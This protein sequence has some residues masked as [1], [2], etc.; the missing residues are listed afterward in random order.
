MG[1]QNQSV[2]LA[3]LREEGT[4][5]AGEIARVIDLNTDVVEAHLETLRTQGY[6]DFVVARSRIRWELADEHEQPAPSTSINEPKT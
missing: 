4:S 3:I 6:V 1:E 5:T 2:I